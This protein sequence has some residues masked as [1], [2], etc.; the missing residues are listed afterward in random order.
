MGTVRHGSFRLGQRINFLIIFNFELILREKYGI[1]NVVSA[2][3][4]EISK[5]KISIQPPTLSRSPAVSKNNFGILSLLFM[6]FNRTEQNVE[7]MMVFVV[8][9][10]NILINYAFE[11]YSNWKQFSSDKCIQFNFNWNLF[12][13][14]LFH[15]IIARRQSKIHN[16]YRA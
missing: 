3:F 1:N 6:F 9:S 7:Y 4:Y 2:N 15:P 12:S 10:R 5:S 16:R 13:W 8:N 14:L 11:K